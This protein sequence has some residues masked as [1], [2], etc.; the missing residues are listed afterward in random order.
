MIKKIIITVITLLAVVA[1]GIK[2]KGLLD[3]RKEEVV[4]EPTPKKTS[5]NVSVTNGENGEIQES[6]T[7]L[8][9]LQSDKS[10]KISTKIAGY[11]KKIYVKEGDR[12]TKGTLLASIDEEDINSNIKLLK[13][14]LA[15][16]YN[17]LALAKQIYNRNK[18]LYN[19]GGLPKEQLDTSKVI[20]EGKSTV[21]KGT[22]EKI[23]QLEHQKTYLTIKAPF[24]G[25]V[26]NILLYGGDL[27]VMG[28]PLLSISSGVKKLVFSYSL[29]STDI[30][31]G[32]KAFYRGE[33][34]GD[35]TTIKPLAKQGLAQA[36]I[37]LKQPLDIP[38]GSSLNIDILIRKATGCIVS[39]KTLIHKK[40][41]IYIM[42][43]N[44]NKFTRLKVK[45]LLSNNEDTILSSCPKEPIAI[46]NEVEL[47]KL[48]AYT[49]IQIEK[50]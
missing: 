36:E 14:T 35:I 13:N 20:L 28:K 42:V 15:Q 48:G 10:I 18:K 40:D 38:L 7:F 47:V 3:K 2:G 45:T 9:L 5:I 12:V 1:V 26:D 24:S 8:A 30:K 17:D 39:N 25:T 19:I 33:N 37:I 27:A 32:E 46:G 21:I 29:D 44:N 49:N 31:K 43:Y 11:I 34:I 4:L 41:G 6:K 50:D 23:A 16:E 22:K